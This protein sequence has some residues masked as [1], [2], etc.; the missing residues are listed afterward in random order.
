MADKSD[1]HPL[2]W[3]IHKI[4]NF[5]G[6][7]GWSIILITMLIKL[8]FYP[9]SEKSYRSMANMRKLA[10][11]LAKLKETY[12]DDKQKMGQ[13]TM[14]LYKQEKVNPVSGCLHHNRQNVIWVH[15]G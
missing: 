10:P 11:R 6:S 1:I 15:G 2:S 7:W 5:V 3:G 12:G 14:E 8:V 9:L 4:N 13:K